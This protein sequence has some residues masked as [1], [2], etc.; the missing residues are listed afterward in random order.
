MIR[1]STVTR[2][3]IRS[4]LLCY[5]CTVLLFGCTSA[6]LQVLDASKHP[7]VKALL[8]LGFINLT[9]AP[10]LTLNKTKGSREKTVGPDVFVFIEGDGAPWT[11][12]GTT[13]PNDPTP[14]RSLALDLA[15]TTALKSPASVLYVARPCQFQAPTMF[16]KCATEVWASKRYGNEQLALLLSST[17]QGLMSLEK[18]IK[19]KLRLSLVGHS[20]G[21][22]RAI[23]VGAELIRR[24]YE[25]VRVVTLASPIDP[26]TW[27]ANHRF[28]TLHVDTYYNDMD[29]I[30]QSQVATHYVGKN[31]RLVVLGDT[32]ERYKYNPKEITEVAGVE[33]VAGWQEYWNTVILDEI[34]H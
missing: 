20:G 14:R 27:S 18:K 22:V 32:S 21:G 11:L 17:E 10:T 9:G 16:I 25:V 19:P 2:F 30:A 4:D 28:S 15:R 33:H 5:L 1:S 34:S 8:S 3:S 23:R 29:L 24:G 31:D 6:E 13:P 26:V 7:Q 12:F